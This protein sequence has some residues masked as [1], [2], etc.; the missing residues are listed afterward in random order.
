MPNQYEYFL[1]VSEHTSEEKAGLGIRSFQ[2]NVPF[3]RSFLF[4]I[5]ERNV[6]YIL[7]RSL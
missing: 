2:K 1:C 7:F 3:F 4:F 6:L 5:K